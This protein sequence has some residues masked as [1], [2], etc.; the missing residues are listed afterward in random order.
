[1]G[2]ARRAFVRSAL[3][4]AWT[5][6]NSITIAI[7]TLVLSGFFNPVMFR[8]ILTLGIA[9]LGP[10][11][12]QGLETEDDC[13][14]GRRRNS[15]GDRGAG[16]QSGHSAL[17]AV[18]DSLLSLDWVLRAVG[19]KADANGHGPRSARKSR[20]DRLVRDRLVRARLIPGSF[21]SGLVFRARS[22]RILVFPGLLFAQAQTPGFDEFPMNIDRMVDVQNQ[23]LTTIQE[24]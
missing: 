2:A 19:I 10:M 22:L 12:A 7:G 9:G 18:P 13:R 5:I 8:N 23:P 3:G 11:T 4:G 16:R 6:S 14:S 24:A 21:D 15:F 17:V 20:S 1:L